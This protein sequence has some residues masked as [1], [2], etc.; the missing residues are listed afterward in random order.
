MQDLDGLRDAAAVALAA[1]DGAAAVS[2]T[3]MDAATEDSGAAELLG[4]AANEL[5]GAND[6]EL[7]E[8]SNQHNELTSQLSEISAGLGAFLSGL[9]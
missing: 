5:A 2:T 3:G 7:T 8:F 1:I 6:D 4:A 9:P